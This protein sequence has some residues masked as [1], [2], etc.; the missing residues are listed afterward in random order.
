MRIQHAESSGLV[1]AAPEY[2]FAYLDDHARLSSHMS[3]SSWMLGGGRMELTL[4]S[5]QGRSVGSVIR[6]DGVAFGVRLFVEEV[7]TERRPPYRKAWETVGVP[8][9][10]VI[11]AYRMGFE[12]GPDTH[13]SR[14]RVFLDYE[15][16]AHGIER[17]L[18]R[19]LGG[20]YAR[21][22]ARRML[23]DAVKRFASVG[24]A[25][26]AGLGTSTATTGR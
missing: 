11:G 1:H 12:L 19:A 21:W 13:S 10:L 9:L 26:P 6:L 24:T 20:Y 22:C 2:V 18:G 14:L 8:R 16:P 15:L 7:V 25:S 4:D 23:V 3:R 5:Q 17:W